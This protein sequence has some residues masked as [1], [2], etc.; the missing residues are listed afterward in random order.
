MELPNQLETT[1]KKNKKEYGLQA[2]GKGR[3]K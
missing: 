1:C 3:Q 2:Q